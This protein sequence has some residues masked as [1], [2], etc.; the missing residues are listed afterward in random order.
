MF[1]IEKAKREARIVD[2]A[3]IR[4]R[5]HIVASR[6]SKIER[7][8]RSAKYIQR[9]AGGTPEDIRRSRTEA[10]VEWFAAAALEDPD[11][12]ARYQAFWLPIFAEANTTKPAHV[13]EFWM[14]YDDIHSLL[15][16][17]RSAFD[18]DKNPVE[19]RFVAVKIMQSAKELLAAADVA[20]IAVRA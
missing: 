1:D 7:R 20:E 3:M 12:S 5:L 6:L 11:M 9:L 18:K 19:A 17:A 8:T 13:R 10:A 15:G 14:I 16:R 4:R 2:K